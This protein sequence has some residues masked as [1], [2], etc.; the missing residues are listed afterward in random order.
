M[1]ICDGC[2]R[3]FTHAGYT[4]HLRHTRRPACA[5]IYQDALNFI[6]QSDDIEPISDHDNALD[7]LQD[8]EWDDPN[9]DGDPAT[10]PEYDRDDVV[11]DIIPAH[12]PEQ[13]LTPFIL[14]FL[15]Y[16]TKYRSTRRRGRRPNGSV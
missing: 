7:G 11:P 1:P 9:D 13:G 4:S 2:A 10:E 3:S 12:E 16:F 5:A 15:I 14:L 8:R 6:A